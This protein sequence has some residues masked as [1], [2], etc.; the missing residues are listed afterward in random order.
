MDHGGEKMKTL[1]EKDK[2]E[3]LDQVLRDG[4]TYQAKVWGCLM[5][6]A[7]TMVAIGAVLGQFSGGFGALTNEYCYVGMTNNRF[8]FFVMSSLDCSKVKYAFEV[9]F[10]KIDK[11]K[12]KKSL[13][14]GRQLLFI[15]KE[16]SK[17]K[18]SL[19][20]NSIGT[21]IKDQKTGVETIISAMKENLSFN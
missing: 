4:E 9:P 18:L 16:K 17:L 2:N 12:V 19:M 7:K 13:I 3:L 5:A 14:P 10:S 1:N 11:V 15:H 21:D 8:V 20:T 6:D